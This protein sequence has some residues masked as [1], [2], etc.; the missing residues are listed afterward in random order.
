MFVDYYSLLEISCDS[1]LIEIK[2]AYKKQAM[3][4]HPDKNSQDTTQK[5]QQINEARLILLDEEARKRYDIE[6][7]NFIKSQKDDRFKYAN[8]RKEPD[9]ESKESKSHEYTEY[10]IQD[11]VLANWIQNARI[12]AKEIIKE[13]KELSSV[14]VIAAL[15]EIKSGIG[16]WFL[17][18]IIFGIII[19]LTK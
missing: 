18:I 13:T 17:A 14:G 12:Q 8:K 19:I 1:S 6:Y 7:L 10:N 15:K 3:R 2:N 5:M 16:C 9:F 11:A 4:W